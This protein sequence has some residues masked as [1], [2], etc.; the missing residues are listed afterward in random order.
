MAVH[1][2]AAALTMS[3]SPY[4]LKDDPHSS[5]SVI[6]S[7][8]GEG[9]GR[10]GAGRGRGRRL[11]RRAPHR[12]G[13]ERDRARARPGAGRARARA[14]QGG[15]GG[16]PGVG[17]PAA[18]RSLRR[19]RLRRRARAPERSAGRPA[20]P[21]P[22]PGARGHRDRLGAQRRASL[23]A[24]V[25][26]RGPLRLRRSR[27]PGSHPPPLLHAAHLAR[28]PARGRAHAWSSSRS[29]RCRCRWW[30]RR[31]GTAAWLA[32]VHALSAGAARGWPGGLAYQFVAVCRARASARWPRPASKGA[33]EGRGGDARLQRG[34]DAPHDLR[35]AA[36]GHR[37][38]GHPGGR[39]LD[40]R[41]ARGRARAR[42]R[43]LRPR[44][45]LRLRRQ[46]EDLLHRG[47]QGGRRHRGDGPSRLPVRSHPGAPDH[48]AH[49]ARR[50]RSRPG[51]A[52]RGR[53]LGDRAGDA[54][55]EVRGQ[56]VPDRGGEPG[57]RSPPVRVP[58]RLPRVQP[59]TC[60]TP[61]TSA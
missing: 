13:L 50:G 15:G 32:R 58:H 40:R 41:H 6:L 23:G 46:P 55:V 42:A 44:P 30:C 53:R 27:H 18:A 1:A 14:L 12:P 43:D 60:S 52:A 24:P 5:H 61:S 8:L 51:L 25:A 57:L 56:P 47:P 9:R 16:R 31:A 38:P 19:H 36:E 49:R 34:P 59:R 45:E 7:R 28:A 11:P 48:R 37:E 29:P 21:R 54:V 4:R 3:V 10:T 17:A 2:R 35:G 33:P 39:R 22:D 20:R 26:P